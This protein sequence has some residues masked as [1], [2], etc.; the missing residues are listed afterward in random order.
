MSG[1]S[2]QRI[3]RPC[4][5]DKLNGMRSGP[6]TCHPRPPS[7]EQWKRSFFPREEGNRGRRR[8]ERKCETAPNLSSRSAL[9]PIYPHP[10][11]TLGLSPFLQSRPAAMPRRR[12]SRSGG[13]QVTIDLVDSD[14]ECK[15]KRPRRS[16]KPAARTAGSSKSASLGALT[17]NRRS[18]RIATS[19]RDKK[20]KDKLNTDIFESYLEDLWKH[21]DEEKRSAYAY[22]DSL[23]FNMYNSG[24]NKSNVLKWIKSKKVFSRQYVFVPIV[25]WGHWNLLVLCNFG[26][27]DYLGTDKGPRMLLLDSLKTTNPTRLRLA[28][29]RS[30][31]PHIPSI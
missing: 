10:D 5:A 2:A 29:R 9:P 8:Q 24:H 25:C 16:L 12:C 30:D 19:N 7:Q 13:D 17:T 28:I 15:N 21:I 3:Q 14:E 4:A 1:R 31:P 23:W 11:R 26:E 20:N 6:S 18:N 27:T 22:F